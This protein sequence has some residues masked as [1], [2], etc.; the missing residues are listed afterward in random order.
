MDVAD[1]RAVHLVLD[2][3]LESYVER[4]CMHRCSSEKVCNVA[5]IIRLHGTYKGCKD[6]ELVGGL[7]IQI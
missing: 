6:V 4:A 1:D 3:L 2:P 5:A 7:D